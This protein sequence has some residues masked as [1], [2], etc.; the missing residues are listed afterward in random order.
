[1]AIAAGVAVAVLA[2]AG[3]LWLA[4]R[5]SGDDVA[6]FFTLA[7]PAVCHTGE[8]SIAVNDARFAAFLPGKQPINGGD[9]FLRVD[10]SIK[11][12]GGTARA[13][14]A[15]HFMLSEQSGGSYT[16]TSDAGETGI[17]STLEPGETASGPVVFSIPASIGAAKLVYDDGCTRQ[18]WVVP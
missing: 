13:I 14:D 3:A 7:T 4:R 2:G 1:M 16:E 8:L 10:V 6:R 18:E 15:A 11:N 9:K 5:D 17:T 12:N